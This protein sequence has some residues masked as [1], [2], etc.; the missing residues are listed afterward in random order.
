MP[1]FSNIKESDFWG[2]NF[3][4]QAYRCM[5]CND[6]CFIKDKNHQGER[7][8]IDLAENVFN[9]MPEE[10]KK[11]YKDL[12]A[13]IIERKQTKV[14]DPYF[15]Q[16][17]HY[18]NPVQANE[19]LGSEIAG[20]FEVISEVVKEIQKTRSTNGKDWFNITE[21]EIKEAMGIESLDDILSAIYYP[22][23]EIVQRYFDKAK[24]N[25]FSTFG[26][27]PLITESTKGQTR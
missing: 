13:Y 23:T 16:K 4:A 19:S 26:T 1:D 25:N 27:N 5:S 17:I 15:W 12:L 11:Q 22:R 20:V 2:N 18:V 14:G 10:I 8:Y 9:G 3:L 21:E 6:V 7:E 24:S